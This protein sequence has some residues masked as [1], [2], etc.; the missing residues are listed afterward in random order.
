MDT[1]LAAIIADEVRDL[2][3]RV[4]LRVTLREEVPDGANVFKARYVLAFKSR[5]D[6][7]VKRRARY[8]IGGHKDVL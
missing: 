6:G 7:T 1:R 5:I 2:L 8:V 4:T 3:H